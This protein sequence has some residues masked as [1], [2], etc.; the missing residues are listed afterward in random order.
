VAGAAALEVLVACCAPRLVAVLGV[1]AYRTA[2][3]RRDAALGLQPERVGGRPVWALPNPSGLNARYQV[4]DLARLYGE[5]R[6]HA[7]TLR[8]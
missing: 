2:F 8:V 6:E 5:A 4:P 1:T 7:L 3:G